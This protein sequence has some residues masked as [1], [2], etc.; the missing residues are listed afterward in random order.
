MAENG[1]REEELKWLRIRE[2]PEGVLTGRQEQAIRQYARE[3]GYADL[4]GYHMHLRSMGWDY[5]DVL[6]ITSP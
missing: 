5:Y 4:R 3:E 2:P 1:E 6:R